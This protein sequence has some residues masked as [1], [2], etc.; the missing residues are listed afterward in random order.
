M[1]VNTPIEGRTQQTLADRLERTHWL[2]VA[3]EIIARAIATEAD[4]GYDAQESG[5]A[6]QAIQWAQG[7]ELACITEALYEDGGALE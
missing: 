7:A 4:T 2:C 5:L 6:I 3:T 1:R